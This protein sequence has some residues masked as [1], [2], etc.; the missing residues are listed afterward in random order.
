MTN[1]ARPYATATPVQDAQLSDS[2]TRVELLWVENRVEH[3]IRFGHKAREQIL[4]AS[5]SIVSFRPDSTFA[6]VR[7]ESNDFGAIVSRI[8]IVRAVRP[9]EA[10]QTLPFVR[11]GG[12]ILLR[13][14]N[15]STVGRVLRAIDTIERL[16]IE[17]ESVSPE[18]WR[19]VHSRLI[20]GEAPPP[21]TLNQHRA[22]LS[23][24]R[25]IP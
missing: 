12:D 11:P 8:D 17:P 6:L 2:L 7:W 19:H 10:C 21:Y 5:R 18:H 14:E 24:R 23:R 16:G 13:I 25:F 9:G 1:A 4:N 20:A 22:F 3:W 15:W